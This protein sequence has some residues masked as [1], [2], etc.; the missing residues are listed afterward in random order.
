MA[1]TA[2][3]D[4]LGL[5]LSDPVLSVLQSRSWVQ[6][7]VSKVATALATVRAHEQVRYELLGQKFDAMVAERDDL[8]ARTAALE[9]ALREH[10]DHVPPRRLCETCG[11]EP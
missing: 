1:Q 3:D 8:R 6:R 7:I 5:N 4:G 10:H 2:I 9:G 11:L